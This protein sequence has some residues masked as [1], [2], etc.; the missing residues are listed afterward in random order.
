MK[1]TLYLV[2]FIV[3][4][5]ATTYT[6]YGF[7]NDNNGSCNTTALDFKSANLSDAIILDV[8]TQPEFDSGHIEG[9]L[10]IDIYKRDFQERIGR[11][12][13]NKT[14]YVYCKT[15][16]RSAHAMRFMEQS[17]FNK[18]CNLEGGINQLKKAGIALVK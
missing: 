10:L 5:L 4:I 11:L 18:V 13:K 3:A 1:K 17:G 2:I 6:L 16:A 7:R 14:Y 15:G 12:D 9:A 8:R